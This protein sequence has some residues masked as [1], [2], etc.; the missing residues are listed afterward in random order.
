MGHQI[1]QG[2]KNGAYPRG[3]RG[4]PTH[5]VPDIRPSASVNPPFES[6]PPPSKAVR[7]DGRFE[8]LRHFMRV[9]SPDHRKELF[10]VCVR[11]IPIKDVAQRKEGS[12][13]AVSML[14]YPALRQLKTAFGTSKSPHLPDR[15]FEKESHGE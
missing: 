11:D 8:H 12:P 3:G 10:L 14:L 4:P 13:E 2:E 9:L 6:S 15:P 1:V 7:R 5:F